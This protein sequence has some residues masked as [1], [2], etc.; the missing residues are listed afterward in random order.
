MKRP[1]DKTPEPPGGRA[2]ERL[3]MFEYARRGPDATVPDEPIVKAPAKTKAK[4]K[5]S[6]AAPKKT[7]RRRREKQDR[8]RT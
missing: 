4:G 8:R 7:K 1:G 6:R 2:A 3:R 5:A